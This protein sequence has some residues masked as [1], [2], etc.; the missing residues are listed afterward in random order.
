MY[1]INNKYYDKLINNFEESVYN[2]ENLKKQK[3]N[4]NRNKWAIDMNWKKLQK[5]DNWF[6]FNENLGYQKE[7]YSDIEKQKVNYKKTFKLN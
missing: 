7:D 6:I 5:K 3:K 1:I 4:I 2:M